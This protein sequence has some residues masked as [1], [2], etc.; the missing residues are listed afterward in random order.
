MTYTIDW[1]AAGKEAIQVLQDLIRLNTTNPPGNERQAAEYIQHKLV[2]VGI[3]SD[4]LESGPGRAN[5]VAR[6]ASGHSAGP[7]LL[8]GHTDVVYADPDEWTHP[9]FGGEI[10][11]DHVWGR[12]AMDMKNLLTMQLM[13]MLLVKRLDLPLQRDLILLAV[14]DEEAGGQHGAQ[15]V[16]EHH[17]DKVEAEYVLGEGGRGFELNSKEVYLVATA[18]KGYGDLELTVRGTAGH[19]AMPRGVNPVVTISQALLSVANFAPPRRV[20]GS[21]REMV[22][23]LAPLFLEARNGRNASD[24]IDPLLDA[25]PEE[26]GRFLK[27]ALRDVYSPTIVRGGIKE[28]VIPNQASANV[29][30]RTLPGVTQVALLDT[31]ESILGGGVEID[32]KQFYPGSESPIHSP[33]MEAIEMVMSETVPGSIVSPYMLPAMTDARF[34]RYR[35]ANAYGFSPVLTP[36]HLASTIHGKDERFPVAFLRLGTERLFRIVA[37]LCGK[38]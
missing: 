22:E 26:V 30:V 29:N 28:N 18:E 35:G 19:A 34:F 3:K 6:L 2:G 16:V 21:I 32:V 4:I 15:W 27:Y 11:D 23:R 17:Y 10:H 5:L 37:R 1:D 24:R 33:L 36:P 38:A 20:M 13:T 31:M 25:L 7:V 8:L 9:P 14:A 12:G